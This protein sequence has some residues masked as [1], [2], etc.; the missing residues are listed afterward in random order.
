MRKYHVDVDGV[1]YQR[2]GVSINYASI[3]YLDQYRDLKMFYEE[4]IGKELLSPSVNYIDMKIHY[5][6][7]LIDLRFQVDHF[8]PKKFTYFKKTDMIMVLKL[9]KTYLYKN[10][11]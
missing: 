7:Q 6:I 11:I 4:Y 9:I 1:R 8:Y 3:D 5:T 2:N 10:L